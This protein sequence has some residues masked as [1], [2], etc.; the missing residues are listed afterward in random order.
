MFHSMLGDREAALSDLADYRRLADELR[1]PFF[2]FSALRAET[3]HALDDG[4]LADV[5]SSSWK[6]RAVGLRVEPVGEVET[7]AHLGQDP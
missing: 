5:R 2:E 6:C 7:K 4:R 1:Q 3:L